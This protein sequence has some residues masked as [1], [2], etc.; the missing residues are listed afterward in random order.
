MKISYASIMMLLS[1]TALAIPN[2]EAYSQDRSALALNMLEARKSC[3]DQRDNYDR[4]SGKRLG[5]TSSFHN[6][7]DIHRPL[8]TFIRLTLYIASKGMANAARKTRTEAVD[9][10]RAG[11]RAVRT[12][13]IVSQENARHRQQ[14]ISSVFTCSRINLA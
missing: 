10:I 7:S 12:V 9:W 13:A 14:R 5:P 1:M 6:W 3:S 4:C 11:A 2:P 8:M